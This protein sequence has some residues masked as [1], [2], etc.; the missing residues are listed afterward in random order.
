MSMSYFMFLKPPSQSG[1]HSWG[2]K[3]N[4]IKKTSGPPVRWF[5]RRIVVGDE[6]S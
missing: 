1:S 2:R 4:E 3:S 6:E 5:R